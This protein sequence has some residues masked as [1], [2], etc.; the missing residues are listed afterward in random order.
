MGSLTQ[1]ALFGF[2]LQF[3][4]SARWAGRALCRTA[5]AAVACAA[6]ALAAA[7]AAAKAVDAAPLSARSAPRI[8]AAY[9]MIRR[10]MEGAATR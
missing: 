4:A 9:R 10:P 1:F 2:G 5:A 3:K 6:N 7:R 8:E